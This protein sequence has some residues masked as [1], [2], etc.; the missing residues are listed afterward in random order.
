MNPDYKEI[1]KNIR[2]MRIRQGVSQSEL[3]QRP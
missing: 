2:L 3:A 1:G